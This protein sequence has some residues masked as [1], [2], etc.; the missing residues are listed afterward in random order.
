MLPGV[1]SAN[2]LLSG[3]HRSKSSYRQI[4]SQTSVGLKLLLAFLLLAAEGAK[5][6][7][8][9]LHCCHEHYFPCSFLSELRGKAEKFR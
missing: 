7:P 4:E 6:E 3:Q 1:I 9:M 8:E 2:Q 5:T